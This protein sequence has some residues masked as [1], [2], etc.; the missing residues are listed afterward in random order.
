[1]NNE[2]AIEQYDYK[3]LSSTYNIDD[4]ISF[5]NKCIGII[6]FDSLYKYQAAVWKIERELK[7]ILK[8]DSKIFEFFRLNFLH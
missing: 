6:D 5:D 1:M 7:H 8:F 3:C 2:N 4:S